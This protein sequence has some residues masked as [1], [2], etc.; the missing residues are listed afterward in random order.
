MQ[1]FLVRNDNITFIL[2]KGLGV[3]CDGAIFVDDQ[4]W[5]STHDHPEFLSDTDLTHKTEGFLRPHMVNK[6]R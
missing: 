1:S 3:S 2:V 4:I 5:R 6:S